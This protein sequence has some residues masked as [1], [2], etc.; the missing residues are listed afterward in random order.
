MV[1]IVLIIYNKTEECLQ[2]DWVH[3][4]FKSR[5]VGGSA[6]STTTTTLL[7]VGVVMVSFQNGFQY[8]EF[9]KYKEIL[10]V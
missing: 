10:L 3:T 7:Q 2:S 5:P 1:L 6:A 9:S 8:L 4:E